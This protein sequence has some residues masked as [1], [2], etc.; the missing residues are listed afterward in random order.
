MEPA[1]HII[2]RQR[3]KLR[4][5]GTTDILALRRMI[6]NICTDELPVRL[7][8]LLDRYDDK[9]FVLRIDKLNVSISINEGGDLQEKLAKAIIEKVEAVLRQRLEQR[10]TEALSVD[11]SFA[12]TLRF[13]LEKGYL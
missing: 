1:T 5:N 13:Y 7:N 11:R 10:V 4:Y 6:S 3:I 2:A 12:R 8:N 9:D